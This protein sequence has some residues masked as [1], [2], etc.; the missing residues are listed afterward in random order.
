MLIVYISIESKSVRF[1]FVFQQLLWI[2]LTFLSCQ[3]TPKNAYLFILQRYMWLIPTRFITNARY[4]SPFIFNCFASL[5]ISS[6]PKLTLDSARSASFCTI[7][8]SHNKSAVQISTYICKHIQLRVYSFL[9]LFF[10][11]ALLCSLLI[12]KC[13]NLFAY[14]LPCKLLC[15]GVI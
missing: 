6:M 10:A 4:L 14:A 2:Y 3:H 13:I 1:R 5:S 15:M 11:C 8:S 9:F 7:Y 12:Y